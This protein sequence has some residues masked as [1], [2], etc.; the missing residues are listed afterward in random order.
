MDPYVEDPFFWP[1]FHGSVIA[2]MRGHLNTRLPERYVASSDR[3]VWLE[4]PDGEPGPLLGE[5]DGLVAV[6]SEGEGNGTAAGAATLSAPLTVA[7]PAGSPLGNR[8]LRIVDRHQ[9]RV[10]TVIELLSPSNKTAGA[11][12]EAY[13]FKR[14]EYLAG[15]VNL[16]EIDLLR[17]GE[18]PPL[19][20]P[21]TALSDYYILA[22]QA[23]DPDRAGVWT[24][25]VRDAIPPV[26]VPLDPGVPIVWMDL[27]ACT[28]RAYD[29]GRYGSELDYALPPVPPLRDPDAAW[30]KEL[31]AARNPQA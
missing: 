5:P 29:E 27:R 14:S 20:D 3:H 15:G 12:G 22:C 31:L 10:V 30:A 6:R 7:I 28:D 4:E 16:V 9:R 24:F 2:A 8:Y 11:N 23:S 1:D 21:P 19:G 17:E 18:R 26:P 13:R 25:S